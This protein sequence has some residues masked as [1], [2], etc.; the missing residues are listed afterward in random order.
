MSLELRSLGVRVWGW[1]FWNRTIVPKGGWMPLF[2]STTVMKV[3]QKGRVSVPAAFRSSLPQGGYQGIVI[4]QSF[5]RPCLEGAD[6]TFMEK[7]SESMHGDFGLYSDDHEALATATL[8]SAHQLPFDP[9]G[10]VGLPKKLMMHAG[11]SDEA[12]FVGLGWKFQIWEPA[13]FEQ[14]NAT[15]ISLAAEAS[16]AMSPLSRRPEGGEQ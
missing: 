10:R 6:L 15:Q 7:L 4:Y 8:G 11:I 14:H 12:T 3:D 9:E 13:A 16:K 5:K 2:L 1:E